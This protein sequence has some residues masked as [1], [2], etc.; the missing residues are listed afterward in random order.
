MLL[1]FVSAGPQA[2]VLGAAGFAAFSTVIDYYLRGHW[3]YR[4]KAG[5]RVDG[6]IELRAVQRETR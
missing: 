1:F 6:I 5:K 3:S 4:D 2:A